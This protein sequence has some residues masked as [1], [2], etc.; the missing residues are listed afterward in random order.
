[1]EFQLTCLRSSWEKEGQG[2]ALSCALSSL[3]A[4]V[5]YRR[6]LLLSNSLLLSYFHLP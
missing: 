2:C 6:L 1:M 3:Q 5:A 4:L